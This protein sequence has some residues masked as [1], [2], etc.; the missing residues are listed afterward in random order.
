[1]VKISKLVIA[2][3][4]LRRAIELYFRGDSYFSALHLAGAAQELLGAFVERTGKMS[5][6]QSIVGAAVDISAILDARGVSSTEK[7]ICRVV[8]HAKNRVKHMDAQKI[9]DE[10]ISFDPQSHAKEMLDFAMSDFYQLWESETALPLSDEIQR[11]SRY[12]V[13]RH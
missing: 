13:E 7:E 9:E 2:N 12:Q 5:R 11:Y 10:F 4:Y 6:R 3:E 8:N 1:M